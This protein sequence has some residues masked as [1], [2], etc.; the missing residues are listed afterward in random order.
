MATVVARAL[1]V[2]EGGAVGDRDLPVLGEGILA[3]HC[4]LCALGGHPVGDPVRH[5]VVVVVADRIPFTAELLIRFGG[6]AKA[7]V[8]AAFPVGGQQGGGSEGEGNS[9]NQFID[10]YHFCD[11]PV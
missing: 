9:Q 8:L 10:F 2:G 7:H 3:R 5:L 11:A 4:A 1:V 6:Q